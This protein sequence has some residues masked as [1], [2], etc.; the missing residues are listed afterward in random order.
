MHHLL[1]PVAQLQGAGAVRVAARRRLLL[2]L[3]QAGQIKGQINGG[4]QPPRP[5]TLQC[6]SRTT[7]DAT[8]AAASMLHSAA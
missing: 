3:H 1:P 2:L 6:W 7:S 5:P 4:Q 8:C